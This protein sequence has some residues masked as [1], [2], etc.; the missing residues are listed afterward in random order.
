MA[1]AGIT[2]VRTGVRMPRMNALME[3]WGQTCRHELLDRTLIWNQHQLPHTLREFEDFYNEHRPHRSKRRG[4][5]ATV[6]AAGTR[7]KNRRDRAAGGVW[8]LD[9]RPLSAC[10][11]PLVRLP[12]RYRF[13][14]RHRGFST[15]SPLHRRDATRRHIGHRFGAGWGG[16]R[17]FGMCSGALGGWP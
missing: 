15:T 10:A 17:R 3:R 1:D 5:R 14:R 11:G 9:R 12:G 7:R 16:A 4:R 8:C 13:D 6:L 2:V